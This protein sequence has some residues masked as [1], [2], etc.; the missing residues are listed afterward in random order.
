VIRAPFRRC[1]GAGDPFGDE[2]SG[3]VPQGI[4]NANLGSVTL[5]KKA[6]RAVSKR[7][8][9]AATNEA[10]TEGVDVPVDVEEDAAAAAAAVTKFSAAL[11]AM[12]AAH[13]QGGG[14]ST[15]SVV[16]RQQQHAYSFEV[17]AGAIDDLRELCMRRLNPPLP[18]IQVRA[19][20][21]FNGGNACDCVFAAHLRNTFHLQKRKRRA[22][23]ALQEYDFRGDSML[24]GLAMSLRNPGDLRPYQ[25]RLLLSIPTSM[26]AWTGSCCSKPPK[27]Q[28]MCTA[29][30]HVHPR[31]ARLRRCLA[32]GAHAPGL[33]CS[34]V[35]Q[36]R[37]G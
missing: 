4:D 25:V 17:D 33:S 20:F 28:L 5:T 27:G 30:V 37:G 1:G 14:G 11:K 24:P 12:Y 2:S 22:S 8:K 23:F 13:S 10:M 31:S 6:E 36:A 29:A 26:R 34:H 21:W 32:T 9:A 35:A 15:S 19:V 7:A 18:L 3:G 16:G